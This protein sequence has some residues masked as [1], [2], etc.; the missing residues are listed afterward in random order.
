MTDTKTEL[1]LRGTVARLVELF[2]DELP[3]VDLFGTEG[4]ALYDNM[5]RNDRSEVA[6]F[7]RAG[8]PPPKQV[9]ELAP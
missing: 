8:G 1:P 9:L 7:L 3:V 4:A 6:E 5:S 2:G